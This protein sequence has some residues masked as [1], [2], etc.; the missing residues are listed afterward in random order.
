MTGLEP[1][2]SPAE[3]RVA[4]WFLQ[5]GLEALAHKERGEIDCVCCDTPI[6]LDPP[7]FIGLIKSEGQDSEL[8]VVVVCEG[9]ARASDGYEDLREMVAEAVG[10]ALAPASPCN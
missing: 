7:P 6:A 5:A 4:A 9:C 2:R 3:E 1:P 8:G 10:G